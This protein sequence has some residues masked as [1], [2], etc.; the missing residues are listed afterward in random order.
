MVKPRE[1]V[2]IRITVYDEYDDRVHSSR[3]I[4]LHM[5]LSEQDALRVFDSLD[6]TK[7]N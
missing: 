3:E 5:V 2:P 4:P 1:A 6:K 7:T